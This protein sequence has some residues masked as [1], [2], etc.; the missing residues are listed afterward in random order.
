MIAAKSFSSFTY[1]DLE[2]LGISVERKFVEKQIEPVMPSSWLIETLNMSRAMPQETEKAKSEL[3]IV[4]ILME[5]V[6]RNDYQLAFFSG[7]NFEVDKS[8]GLKGHCDFLLNLSPNVPYINAPIFAIVEAKKGDFELG[9]PQLIAELHAAYIFN[10]ARNKVLDQ[11]Y[12]VVTVGPTWN[13]VSY[14]PN[15]AIIETEL[16]Y[17]DQ[18]PILL[19]RFQQIIDFWL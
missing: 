17:T 19:G 1:T 2:N 7:Y 6:K 15:K 11:I 8:K 4:P 12:G 5:L 13:F 14:T 18:L 9:F 10:K 16:Y 3:I